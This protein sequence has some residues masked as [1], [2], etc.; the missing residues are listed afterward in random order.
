MKILF[1]SQHAT[2]LFWLVVASLIVGNGVQGQSNATEDPMVSEIFLSLN[3]GGAKVDQFPGFALALGGS[4]GTSFS[5]A[6][7]S[8]LPLLQDSLDRPVCGGFVPSGQG[9]WFPIS[10]IAQGEVNLLFCTMTDAP[11]TMSATVY[12]AASFSEN[13]VPNCEDFSCA[14]IGTK[15]FIQPESENMLK[16]NL[17]PNAPNSAGVHFT[18]SKGQRYYVHVDVATDLANL[19]GFETISYVAD[20]SSSSHPLSSSSIWLTSFT[21]LLLYGFLNW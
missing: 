11:L 8:S 19:T 20:N 2:M 21:A 7:P 4:P 18:A 15:D 6:T 12:L 10:S 17:C 13:E 5:M 9:Y 3:C 16:G 14:A 1:S